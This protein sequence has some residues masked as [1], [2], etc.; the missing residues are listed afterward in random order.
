MENFIRVATIMGLLSVLAF[1]L[2]WVREYREKA[3]DLNKLLTSLAE[4]N[5]EMKKTLLQG[6]V[7]RFSRQNSDSDE[8]P[9]DFERFVAR[10]MRLQYGGKTSVTRAASDFGVDIEHKRKGD[11]YL[12][13]VKCFSQGNSVGFEPIAIIHSQILK[14]GAQG[15]FVV[16][17]SE[18]TNNA[19][20]Y[21]ENLGIELVNGAQLVDM[22]AAS[23]RAGKRKGSEQHAKQA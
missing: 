6:L 20:K 3:N 7:A 23:L 1:G 15:G 12:G 21:A 16:T 5:N 8:T 22:W 2:Y 17:T 10:I 4:C 19:K 14:Q 18:F 11:V 9:L 13:Q